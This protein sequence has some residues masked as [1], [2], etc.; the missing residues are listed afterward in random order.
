MLCDYRDDVLNVINKNDYCFEFSDDDTSGIVPHY[1]GNRLMQDE[2]IDGSCFY[3]V[4]I[5]R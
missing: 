5:V 1:Q 4:F 3:V 2:Y